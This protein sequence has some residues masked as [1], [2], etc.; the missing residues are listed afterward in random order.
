MPESH[1]RIAI[2]EG[3][4][5]GALSDLSAVHLCGSLCGK[6]GETALGQS[7]LCANCGHDDVR[8]I[9]L[10]DEGSLYT[11]TVVRHRPPGNY[12]GP[13]E[14]KPFG[15]G[16][17]ELKEGLR[18][19]APVSQPIDDLCIGMKLRF[20]PYVLRVNDEGKEVVAFEYQSA[21]E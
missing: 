8:P 6:C 18:V 20:R 19:M 16:L 4:L 7:E 10:S 9:S 15:I 1:Q 2:R 14:F 17:I 3:L 13:A 21:G 5:T 12:Q 11:F